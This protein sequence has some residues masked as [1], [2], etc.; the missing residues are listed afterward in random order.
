MTPM[1]IDTCMFL[2]IV[3]DVWDTVQQTYSKARDTT[4]VYEV[5][6]MS[7]VTEY[8]KVFITL[9]L[10]IDNMSD[11]NILFYFKDGLRDRA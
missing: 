6:V 1:I 4:Q 8:I 11:S 2:A 7:S 10:E 3:K 5:K 9:M